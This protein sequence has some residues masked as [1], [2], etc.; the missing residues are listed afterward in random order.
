MYFTH[1]H[2]SPPLERLR[3]PNITGRCNK[4]LSIMEWKMTSHFNDRFVYKLQ[5]EKVNAC[6]GMVL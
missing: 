6:S 1:K 4:S 2:V 3:L 5:I